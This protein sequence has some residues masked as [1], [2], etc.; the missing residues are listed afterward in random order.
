MSQNNH[1]GYIYK[2]TNMQNGLIYIGQ[3]RWNKDSID[4]KY[5]GSGSQ[6]KKAINEY[7]KDSFCC[8]ILEW[9]DS[10]E[11]LDSKEQRWIKELNTTDVTVGYNV[12]I[13]GYRIDANYVS[14][15][16]KRYYSTLTKEQK[17]QR[18]PMYGKH[19]SE[20]TKQLWKERHRGEYKHSDE[21]KRK[22]SASL[23]GRQFSEE[24]KK[25]MSQNHSD[26]SGHNNPMY[27][28]HLIYCNNGIVDK[29]VP[30]IDDIPEGF[31]L[32]RKS[33]GHINKKW[34]NNGVINKFAYECPEGFHPGRI[35][36]KLPSKPPIAK[37]WYTDGVHN[38]LVAECPMG[39]YRG[40]TINK[41]SI[42]KGDN[43]YNEN[44]NENTICG[45][46]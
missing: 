12:Q 20:E 46:E 5:I 34:F 31:V 4:E 23:M 32:G 7:G 25:L 42:N 14:V 18:N 6:L 36:N 28:K 39:F 27:G 43:S 10:Q 9:G 35:M 24:T 1:F 13:G 2:T 38:L 8:E 41:L 37:H 15:G 11:E 3:H 44:D 22:R 26:V 30:T 33:N 19:H 16:L 45:R 29:R 21:T 40:R 17:L